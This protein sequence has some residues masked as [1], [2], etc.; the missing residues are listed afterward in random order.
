MKALILSAG[1]GT[2]LLPHTL[3]MPKPLFPIAGRPVLQLTLDR[4]I[5]SGCTDIIINTHHL[6]RMIETY[7]RE[8]SFPVPVTLMHEPEILDTGGAVKNVRP[9]IGKSPFLVINSDIVTDIDL[10]AA[11]EFHQMGNWPVTMVMHKDDRYNLVA[12]GN[13]GFVTR[14][15]SKKENQT[16]EEKK[17]T[18]AFTGIQVL[19]PEIFDSM[20]DKKTFSSIEL[21]RNLANQGDLVKAFVQERPYWQDIGT[22]ESYLKTNLLFTAQAVLDAEPDP[23]PNPD[24][25]TGSNEKLS[26]RSTVMI[27]KLSGDGSDR[28]WYRA[29]CENSSF[30]IADHGLHDQDLSKVQEVD[31]FI[32]LGN[33]LF[34]KGIPVPKIIQ[35]N[36]FSGLVVL[37]DLGDTHLQKIIIALK[38]ESEILDWYKKVCH[39]IFDLFFKGIEK[40]NPGWPFQTT[41][42]S[43]EV[44]LEAECRYFMEAFVQGHL[45]QSL[46]FDQ[47]KQE[48]EFIADAILENPVSG[49]MHRDMQ[50]RNIMIKSGRPYFIDFQGGR[51]GPLQYDLASLFIDPYVN[52]DNRI[53]EELLRHCSL[54]FNQITGIDPDAFIRQYRYCAVTRNLQILGAFSYLYRVKKKPF[55]KQFIPCGLQRL[56]TG[57]NAIE[58]DRINR[59][60]QIIKEL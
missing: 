43:K 30:I 5:R 2:R 17:N 47:F 52:L 37:E 40:F 9:F 11:W 12:V 31:S 33:H 10:K 53:I 14:F 26:S 38:K 34:S 15:F 21:Y 50:S 36:S 60:K 46:R 41:S 25:D 58:S 18:Y 35:S 44:I 32:A 20:P 16:A 51:K 23:G 13:N 3:V 39:H 22:P 6:N 28:G 48:F 8:T 54:R 19:S 27:T 29:A 7:I 42:Y 49:F 1:Y 59:L 24:S 55:F 56:K 4:L 57:I 45:K